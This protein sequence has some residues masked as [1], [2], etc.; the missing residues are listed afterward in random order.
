MYLSEN[1]SADELRGTPYIK[2]REL[3]R[4]S[5]VWLRANGGR[6]IASASGEDIDKLCTLYKIER[7]LARRIGYLGYPIT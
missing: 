7:E 2:L 5:K 4:E 1:L 3:Q 6:T